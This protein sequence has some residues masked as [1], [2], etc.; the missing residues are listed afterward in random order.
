[1][2]KLHLN[3]VEFY[4]TNVCNFNCENCNRFNNY[5]FSGT[6]L[7]QDYKDVYAKWAQILDLDNFTIL[8]GEPMV[9]P[10]FNEWVQGIREYWPTARG[11][12]NTNGSMLSKSD[13]E[14]YASIAKHADLWEIHIGLHHVN[15]KQH[16]IDVATSWLEGPIDITRTPLSDIP[17]F[18]EGWNSSYAKIKGMDWPNTVTVEEWYLLPDN[19]KDECVNLH[20][21]SPEILVDSTASYILKDVNGVTVLVQFNNFFHQSALI[22]D[23]N[24][25]VKLHNSDVDKAHAICDAKICHTFSK[26]KLSKCGQVALFPEFDKQFGLDITDSDRELINS[27]VPA[28]VNDPSDK[29][30]E[31]VDNLSKPIKQC[32]FCP[33]YGNI[34]EIFGEQGNKIILKK[35]KKNNNA[36]Q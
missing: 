28:D 18:L 29:L 36:L 30:K 20:R 33:E 6:Q 8:G 10:S 14:F 27:Y 9:N 4:I 25:K 23:N 22:R 16:W 17:N 1:M 13:K 2:A 26:G 5:N 12:I 21:F 19:I 35:L 15:K 34:S 11:R 7:W 32:K 3:Y 31:F 24:N